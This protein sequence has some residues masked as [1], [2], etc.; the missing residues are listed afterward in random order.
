MSRNTYEFEIAEGATLDFGL[1]WRADR[2]PWLEVGEN[3]VSSVWTTSDTDITLTDP[4][5]ASGITSVFVSGALAGNCYQIVNTIT[6]NHVPPRT[7]V[8]TIILSAKHR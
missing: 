4:Q 6:T 8:R 7:D 1:N 5:N 2:N 3:I